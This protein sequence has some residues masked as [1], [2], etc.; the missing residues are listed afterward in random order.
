MMKYYAHIHKLKKQSSGVVWHTQD[1]HPHYNPVICFITKQVAE[2]FGII[3]IFTE[4][5][6]LYSGLC[7]YSA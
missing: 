6:G 2:T 4:M 7:P 5:S 1:Q 3:F